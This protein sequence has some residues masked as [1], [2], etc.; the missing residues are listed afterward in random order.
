MY[1]LYIT[2]PC[3]KLAVEGE[4]FEPHFSAMV[5]TGELGERCASACSDVP[6]PQ[7]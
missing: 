3:M 1:L 4:R 2:R 6:D 5:I 7:P